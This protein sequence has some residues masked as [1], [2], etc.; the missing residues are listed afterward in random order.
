M[1]KEVLIQSIRPDPDGPI[2]GQVSDPTDAMNAQIFAHEYCRIHAR[3]F[4]IGTCAIRAV[5]GFDY[6]LLGALQFRVLAPGHVVDG[7]AASQL[8]RGKSYEIIGTDPL[9]FELEVADETNPRIDLVVAVLEADVDAADELRPFVR[10]RTQAELDEAVPPYPPQQFNQP[11]ELHDR[12][13][14][15]VKTGT[16]GAQPVAPDLE[17][18]EEPLYGILVP[19]GATAIDAVYVSDLR[20]KVGSNCELQD[21]IEAL[22]HLLQTLPPVKHRHQADESDLDPNSPGFN[23]GATAQDA[24]DALALRTEPKPGASGVA[25]RPEILTPELVPYAAGSGKLGSSG[26]VISAAPVVR[27]PYPRQVAFSTGVFDLSPAAFVDQSLNPRL[28]NADPDAGDNALDHTEV[29]TLGNV[30]VSDT[31]GGGTWALKAAQLGGALV[32][33]KAA[34]RDGRYI[35]V[36]GI[37]GGSSWFTYDSQAD[38]LTQRNFVGAIPANPIVFAAPCGDGRILIA[39]ATAQG[40][41]AWYAV[42]PTAGGNNCTA[43]GGGPTNGP[44]IYGDLIDVA[45]LFFMVID[46]SVSGAAYWCFHT[47]SDTFEELAVVGAVSVEQPTSFDL[48]LYKQGQA[49]LFQSGPAFTHFTAVF[50]YATRTVTTLNIA[51][52]LSR[53][54]GREYF[55][56]PRLANCNGRPQLFGDEVTNAVPGGTW[57]LT[58]GTTPEWH[59][60]DS[61]LQLRYQPGVASLLSAGLPRGRGFMFGGQRFEY[62]NQATFTDVWAFSAGGVIER[63]CGLTLDDGTRSATLRLPNFQLP[64]AVTKM[65]IAL[66]GENLQGR[67]RVLES[68]DDGAHL[69]EIPINQTTEITDSN[70]NPNRQ[71]FLV[72]T[73]T[74]N[75]RPCVATTHETFEKA[76]GSGLSMVYLVYDTPVGTTYLYI[77][78]HG[79]ITSEAVAAQTTNGKAILHRVV[80]NGALA[81]TLFDFLNKRWFGRK[82]EGGPKGGGVDPTFANDLAVLPSDITCWKIAADGTVHLLENCT[83]VFNG[84]NTVTGL[85]NGESYRVHLA[86]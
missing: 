67:V 11:T 61:A 23:L 68:F 35:E 77:D 70:A 25:L 55:Y 75:I 34:A 16:P 29:L 49:V 7:I 76:G 33:R 39:T 60:I 45:V 38:T 13:V 8:L 6:S 51:Q 24:F 12:A 80:K 64:W 28:V 15:Q 3:D 9:D 2:F 27:I 42:D 58:P 86:G 57:E 53:A 10:L 5:C 40:V 48:C 22:R 50:D 82:Y 69:H 36:F 30:V 43:R 31:D 54:S 19:A 37:N 73:G 41:V 44:L 47:D 62:G 66:T 84:N 72:L 32:G 85:A 56:G 63:P 46:N 18:G 1:P 59:R 4:Y 83:L 74:A 26:A 20:N 17:P 78:E 14:V 52:P 21:R 79:Q 65:I 71:L 81:P